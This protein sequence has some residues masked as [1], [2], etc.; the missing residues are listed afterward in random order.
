MAEVRVGLGWNATP[1]TWVCHKAGRHQPSYL[2]APRQE[3]APRTCFHAGARVTLA[4]LEGVPILLP[5]KPLARGKV[6]VMSCAMAARHDRDRL[7]GVSLQLLVHDT[8][9]E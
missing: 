4:E 9:K 6:V 2:A 8:D 3:Q 5:S 7:D 1:F